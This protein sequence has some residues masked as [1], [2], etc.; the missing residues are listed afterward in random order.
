MTSFV[1]DSF[2]CRIK[3]VTLNVMGPLM[4]PERSIALTQSLHTMDP[5]ILLLQELTPE[6]IAHL[7]SH[8]SHHRRIESDKKCFNTELQIYYKKNLFN[9]LDQGASPLEQVDYPDR[10][11]CWARFEVI[12]RPDV[13]FF[14]A[15]CHMP[16]PGCPAELESGVNQR[17]LCTVKVCEHLRRLAPRHEAIIL[18]GDFN[19]AYQPLRMLQEEIGLTCIFEM[20]DLP[21]PITHPM[22]NSHI[23][24]AGNP[25]STRDWLTCTFPLGSKAIAAYAQVPRGPHCVS[26]HA[27][28]VGIIELK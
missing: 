8:L 19:E 26:D 9:L 24:E 13:K 2:P 27:A 7:D 20:L 11:L 18:A 6:I 1:E 17:L 25:D 23:S 21:P 14:V 22:R 12:S 5:D 3:F 4:W 15:T 10:D 28:V 16:W